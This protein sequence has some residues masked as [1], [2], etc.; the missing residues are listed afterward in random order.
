MNPV[1]NQNSVYM[2]M[3]ILNMRFSTKEWGK[4]S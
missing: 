3:Q 1:N 4:P 2:E